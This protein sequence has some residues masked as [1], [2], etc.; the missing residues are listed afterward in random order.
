[1]S[2]IRVFGHMEDGAPVHEVTLRSGAG[3][4]ARVITWGAVLR[5]M[6]VPLAEG[7]FHQ[8]V[9]LGFEELAHYLAHSPHFGAIAGRFANRIAHGAF[10]LD[11]RDYSLPRNQEGR[12]SL[13]GGGMG[14]GKRLWQLAGH[15]ENWV[16]LT[17]VSPD[18]DHGYPGNV[19]VTCTYRL[20]GNATLRVELSAVTDKATPINLCHH[21]YFNL[22]GARTILDHSLMLSAEFM[23]P[24]DADLIPTGEIRSV[25]G[26]PF[27]FRAAR[28]IHYP[29]SNTG[30]PVKYDHNFVLNGH[31]REASGI[32]GKPLCHAATLSSSVSSISMQCWTTEPAIQVYDGH[33][34]NT[35]VPGLAGAPYGPNAG[36]CLEP[37]HYP[38]SPNRPHFPDTILRPGRVYAQV[39][40]YRF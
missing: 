29:D 7:G 16:T 35:P 33:K 4:V 17:L 36:I 34:V 2:Q 15:G 11:G 3:A 9:V 5:D 10:Q 19:T 22:D 13:H 23:T 21:S 24:V 27:D 40:E 1:M 6:T 14:F 38:D 26:T 30:A 31:C 39:T 37:Q 20:T 32:P 12:H 25:A 28:S 8:R 18:G